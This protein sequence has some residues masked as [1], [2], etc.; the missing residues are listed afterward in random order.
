MF[1]VGLHNEKF[2]RKFRKADNELIRKCIL[3]SLDM[4][5]DVLKNG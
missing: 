5:M 4:G 2:E 1:F 3:E